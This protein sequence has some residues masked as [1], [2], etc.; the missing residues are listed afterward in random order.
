MLDQAKLNKKVEKF[1]K[2]FTK[3]ELECTLNL[4]QTR[5]LIGVIFWIA[6]GFLSHMLI[7]KLF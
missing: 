6:V 5:Y 3:E 4:L 7:I 2:Q 1:K